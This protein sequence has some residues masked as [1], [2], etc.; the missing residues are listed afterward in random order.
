M[1]D[2]DLA[3]GWGNV[4]GSGFAI[5]WSL[6]VEEKIYLF[7]P[8]I[9][10]KFRKS[11]PY[12]GI[13]SVLACFVWRAYLI[14]HGASWIRLSGAFDT[15]VDALM[16]GCL[17]AMLLNVEKIKL[18]LEKNLRTSLIS[19]ALLVFIVFY[20]RGMGGPAGA[21]TVQEQLFYWNVRLPLFS[22]AIAALIVSLISYPQAVAARLLSFAPI[23]WVG[24]ISYSLYLWHIAAFAFA[25]WST[26]QIRPMT[27]AEMELPRYGWAL[28]FASVSFYLVEKPFLRMK[29][30]FTPAAVQ[31]PGPLA[32]R[33]E[34]LSP[35]L[36]TPH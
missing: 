9:V 36:V 19:G 4:M 12:I 25:V 26:W 7:W 30:R 22:L 10:K 11:L 1:C 18:W 3:L 21:H 2:Y 35:V 5:A 32:D 24:R 28:V 14:T 8:S 20:L 29:N 15:K 34:I 31:S 27:L 6:S 23:A 16:F 13:A 33:S 17:A